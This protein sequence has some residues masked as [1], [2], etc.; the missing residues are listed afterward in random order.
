MAERTSRLSLRSRH[1]VERLLQS[2]L[3][4]AA[5]LI[6]AGLAW[7]VATGTTASPIRLGSILEDGTAPDRLMALGMLTLALTPISRVIAL[8]VI[9]WTERDYRFVVTG[10]TVVAVLVMGLLIG[11]G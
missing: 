3:A 6:T 5:A 10:L 2:G 1:I 4:I 7:A 11:H 9:W 8:V